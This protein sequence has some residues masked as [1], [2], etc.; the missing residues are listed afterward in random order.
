MT[1]WFAAVALVAGC[2]AGSGTKAANKT[3]SSG[4][5][6]SA[7]G[8]ASDSG[9]DGTEDPP[10]SGEWRIL[11]YNVHGLPSIITGDDT[12]ARMVQIAPLLQGWDL[13]GLQEDWEEANHEV[14][15]GQATNPVQLWF[16]ETVSSDRYYGSGLSVLSSHPVVA[17]RFVHYTTCHGL[18]DGASDCL[19][20]KGFQAV[21]LQVGA[22][23]VDFYNTHLEAGGGDEDDAAR[24]VQVDDLISSL[25]GW[26]A[27]RAIVFT[28]DFNLRESDPEDAPLLVRLRDEAGLQ[29]A[30]TWVS[31]A[32]ADH[33]DLIFLRSSEQMGLEVSSWTNHSTDF[34]D[35]QGTDL[36]D[37]PPISAKV[38]WTVTN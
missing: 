32:E 24:A 26:S 19:A 14:L 18:L 25:N 34:Q 7:D 6:D 22:G 36:S 30:C 8:A 13:V 38:V 23:Q 29:D 17:Q 1:W 12:P 35:G 2:T 15:I 31:C 5:D 11:S 4:H 9:Q 37:H 16:D 21:R 20:S 3:E 33:S 10:T 27:G 28:G